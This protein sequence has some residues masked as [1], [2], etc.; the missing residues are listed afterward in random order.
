M[1]IT[2]QEK[3]SIEANAEVLP[4]TVNFFCSFHLQKNIETY[5]IGGK[6]KYSWLWFFKLLLN[7]SC[8]ETINKHR[9][10]HLAHI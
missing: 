8:P 6:G 3:G 7:C 1:I 5:V 10:E 9:F 2:D 4:L